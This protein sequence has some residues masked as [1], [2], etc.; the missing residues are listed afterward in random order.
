MNILEN[1]L[2]FIETHPFLVAFLVPL[3]GGEPFFIALA[4]Y[5]GAGG[6][7]PLWIIFIAGTIAD[8]SDD[9][10]WFYVPRWKFTKK[11]KLPRFILYLFRTG[12]HKFKKAEEKDLLLFMM[13]G[14]FILGTRNLAA[15]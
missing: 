13:T 9:I 8:F 6:L 10:F 3:L 5:V 2:P 12:S 15:M 1:L 7:L 4:F 11:I 14:K